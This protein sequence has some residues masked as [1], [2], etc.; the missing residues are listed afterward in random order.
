MLWVCTYMCT[1][2]YV[3]IYIYRWPYIYIL[4]RYNIYIHVSVSINTGLHKNHVNIS[5]RSLALHPTRHPTTPPPLGVC[6]CVTAGDFVA[7]AVED[8]RRPS[9][10]PAV[11]T[12]RSVEAVGEVG[13]LLSNQLRCQESWRNTWV[14]CNQWQIKGFF[15]FFFEVGF[16]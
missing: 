7:A 2:I 8:F 10:S 16:A 6:G 14:S 13:G 12:R 4:N 1:R 9:S 3:C 15:C 11:Q 5:H